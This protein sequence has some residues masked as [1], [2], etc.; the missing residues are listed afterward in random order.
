MQLRHAAEDPKTTSVNRYD[1]GNG[2]GFDNG[3]PDVYVERW[4]EVHAGASEVLNWFAER[5]RAMGWELVEPVPIS[6]VADLR[7][8]RDPDE[9]AGVLLQGFGEWQRHPDRAVNWLDGPN[10][11]R[12]HLA[13]DGTFSDGSTG[14]RVG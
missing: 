10:S 12:V 6:G 13:V 11:M 2:C 14:F 7:L 9:R 3:S 8:S 4:V 5:F 1:E